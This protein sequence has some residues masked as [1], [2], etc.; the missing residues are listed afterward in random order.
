MTERLLALLGAVAAGSALFLA[1]AGLFGLMAHVVARR[2][3]EIGVRLALGARPLGLLARVLGEALALCALGILL[4]ATMAAVGGRWIGGVLHGIT[5]GDPLA[6]AMAAV[7]TLTIACGAGFI[8]ARRA[9]SVD[10]IEAL[11]AE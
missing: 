6:Y 1:T 9:A 4:G 11:R 2:T 8:P 5:P 10:P 3:R 7:L